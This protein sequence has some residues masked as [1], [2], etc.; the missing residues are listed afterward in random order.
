MELADYITWAPMGELRVRC[1]G[2][3]SLRD[4]FSGNFAHCEV[5]THTSRK[6]RNFSGLQ[7][8]DRGILEE[9]SHQEE[10]R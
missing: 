9:V 3:L 1:K 2:I 8:A 7:V 6:F 5:K 4:G 10:A